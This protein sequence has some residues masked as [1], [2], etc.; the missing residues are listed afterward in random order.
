LRRTLR[1]FAAALLGSSV[2]GCALLVS[3]SGLDDGGTLDA[4]PASGDGAATETDVAEE[5]S[6]DVAMAKDAPGASDSVGG[7]DVQGDVAADIDSADGSVVYLGCFQDSLAARDLPYLAY[8]NNVN[9]TAACVEACISAGYHYAGT[10]DGPQCFCGNA[11]GGHGPGG[12]CISPCAGDS[13]EVC[14]GYYQNSVYLAIGSTP[15][16]TYV[17]CYVDA[18]HVADGAI[19]TLPY[20]AYSNSY[21]TVEACAAACAYHGYAYSGVEADQCFCGNG[22]GSPGRATGCMTRCPGDLSET[23][24]GLFQEDVYRTWAPADAGVD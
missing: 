20:A 6:N 10:Q 9:T 12:N 17:G 11:Y 19:R 7:S 16:P 18:I 13:S 22:Y 3:F 21:N 2:A 1:A 8:S 23:C 4:T 15:R 24:G 5:A 14:G